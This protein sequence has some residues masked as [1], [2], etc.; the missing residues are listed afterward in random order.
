MPSITSISTSGLQAAQVR[1][2]TSAHNIANTQTDGFHRQTVV[3]Q[4]R[5]AGAGVDATVVRSPTEAAALAADVVEQ[6][7]AKNAF[8]ANA[9][10]LRTG[11]RVLGS[12]LDDRA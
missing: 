9:A 7:S 1:L 6:L 4:A 10:V 5:P 2:Q 11:N 12:L 3:Q 8:L